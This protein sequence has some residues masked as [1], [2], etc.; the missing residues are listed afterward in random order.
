MSIFKKVVKVAELAK[1]PQGKRAIEQAR[2]YARD[3]KNK[4]KIDRVVSKVKG[5]GKSH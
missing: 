3:P 1:S 5:R 2:R 4:E